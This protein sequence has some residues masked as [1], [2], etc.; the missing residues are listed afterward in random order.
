MG[1]KKFVEL[2]CADPAVI[3][4]E[5]SANLTWPKELKGASKRSVFL[6]Q[7]QFCNHFS[8]VSCGVAAPHTLLYVDY[9]FDVFGEGGSQPAF[10]ALHLPRDFA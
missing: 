5:L 7:E 4:S 3:L 8:S 10:F 2:E 9:E 6:S 1:P